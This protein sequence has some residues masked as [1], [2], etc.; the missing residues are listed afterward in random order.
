[1]QAIK[2]K[3][4]AKSHQEIIRRV[5]I[6]EEEQNTPKELS[7]VEQTGISLLRKLYG[8]QSLEQSDQERK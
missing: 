8:S 5:V 2:D 4:L 6:D 1:M 3:E 7:R